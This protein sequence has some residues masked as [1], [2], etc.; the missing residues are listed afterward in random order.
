M[1]KLLLASMFFISQAA[2]AAPVV[3]G[4]VAPTNWRLENYVSGALV[5]WSTGS[6]CAYGRVTV[7]ASATTQEK[8]RFYASLIAAKTSNVKFFV[9]Y[10]NANPECTISSF[11]V[12]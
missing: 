9:V 7:P 1:K 2:S 5:A 6:S 3:L 8:N 11:G 4:P 12:E 10:D